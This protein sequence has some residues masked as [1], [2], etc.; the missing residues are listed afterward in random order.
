VILNVPVTRKDM[1]DLIGASRQPVSSLLN[2][3]AR[4]GVIQRE[5]HRIIPHEAKLREILREQT[6]SK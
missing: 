4:D 2:D 3:F 6:F 5:R 1:G